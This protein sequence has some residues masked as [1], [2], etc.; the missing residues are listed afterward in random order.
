MCFIDEFMIY[1]DS[2]EEDGG[3]IATEIIMPEP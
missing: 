1:I 2:I 3:E